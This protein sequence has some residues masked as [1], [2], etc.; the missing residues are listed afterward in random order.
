MSLNHQGLT[1]IQ[2]EERRKQG[3][4][5]ITRNAITKTGQQIFR[6]NVCTLFNLLNVLI[7]IALFL[8]GAYSNMF[9]IVIIL[10][11]IIIGITQEMKAKKRIEELSLLSMPEVIVLRDGKE[12]KINVSDIVLDDVM[13]LTAGHQICCDAYVAEGRAEVNEALLTGEADPVLKEEG[14]SLLSGS[15]LISGKCYAVVKHVGN[16]NYAAKITQEARRMKDTVS[17]L[18]QSMRKITKATGFFIIPLGIILF[19]EAFLM[20]SDSMF[21]AVVSSAAGLLGMLPKGLVLLISVSLAGG[22]IKLSKQ[23]IL[24]QDMFSLEALSHVDV[25]CLDKTGT[26]TEGNMNVENVYPLSEGVDVPET[27]EHFMGAYLNYSDDNNA[28]FQALSKY[29][30]KIETYRVIS[31]VPFSSDRKWSSITL[32]QGITFVIGAPERVLKSGLPAHLKKEMESGKRLLIAGTTQAGVTADTDLSQLPIEPL[33]AVCIYDR[34]REHAPEILEYFR[35]EGVNVKIISGD[36]AVTV[37][38]VAKEAGLND[39]ENVIDMMTVG[40]NAD[41]GGLASRYSVFGRTNP[42]QKKKLVQALR[43]QGHSV[44]MTGDGV[45]DLLALKEADCS[46]AVGN[47]S[48]AARQAAQVVLLE[49]DFKALPGL[50]MEGRR[51]VNHV[52]RVAGVFFIKTIYSVILTIICVLANIPFPFIPIQITFIDAVIEAYPAFLTAFEADGRKIKGRFLP[53]AFRRAL[54]NAVAIVVIFLISI[55]V[56]SVPEGEMITALFLVMSIVSM[57]AVVK[58][59]FPF[60]KLRLFVSVTMA[61]GYAAALV[62]FHKLLCLEVELGR[63]TLLL[64]GAFLIISFLVERVLTA[65]LNRR[66]QTV[67]AE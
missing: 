50:L 41:F 38:M 24:I 17:E 52:T 7:A 62:L 47:G 12:K 9:F 14:D 63:N 4:Q 45:N 8:V 43:E 33:A 65:L 39:Y 26:L 6:E 25:L 58:N 16:D 2:V 44:A 60:T 67:S 49:S 28:T 5:N 22:V 40:E 20:R 19:L 32:E 10:I 23:K 35:N 30:K 42:Q 48:D 51:V 1:S 11:N 36:N 66:R 15:S 56:P 53:S 64:G 61:V 21:T 18:M 37:S 27:L 3:M 55:F 31:N 54:P 59:N 46:I 29:F 13:V 57:Q 34:V